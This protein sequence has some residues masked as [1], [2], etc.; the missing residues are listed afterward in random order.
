ML[1]SLLVFDIETIPDVNSCKNLLNV[2]DDSSVEEKRDALTKYHL[3]ITNGQ[4]PFLS[5]SNNGHC[6]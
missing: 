2:S 5:T 3:E 1:N 6:A 4:N